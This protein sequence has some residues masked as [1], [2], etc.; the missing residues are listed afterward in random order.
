MNSGTVDGT[1]VPALADLT[2][3]NLH[4]ACFLV[5]ISGSQPTMQ[6]EVTQSCVDKSRHEGLLQRSREEGQVGETYQKRESDLQPKT[7]FDQR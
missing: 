7:C 4:F 1:S 5:T 3:C 2:Y 6:S